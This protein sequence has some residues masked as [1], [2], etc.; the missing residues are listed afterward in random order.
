[1]KN[2]INI[3]ND[4][5]YTITNETGADAVIVQFL[6]VSEAESLEV[7]QG[8]EFYSNAA[9]RQ[10][11]GQVSATLPQEIFTGNNV[12]FRL[13]TSSGYSPFFH[14]VYE[15]NNAFI[16]K[17]YNY[18]VCGNKNIGGISTGIYGNY[19]T[20]DDLAAFLNNDLNNRTYGELRGGSL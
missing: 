16:I 13:V 4:A 7:Y 1:M 12:H 14:I 2:V 6:D 18:V 15:P 19:N 20:Y 11:G 5:F 9:C 10:T 8:N 3:K 17:Q